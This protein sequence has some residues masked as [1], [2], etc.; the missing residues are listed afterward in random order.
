MK[1]L[2]SGGGTA[3]HINPAIAIADTIRK[4]IPDVEILFVGAE[5][6]MPTP[7]CRSQVSSAS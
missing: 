1:V 6:R 7:Q 4:N 3:G 5:G 2:M